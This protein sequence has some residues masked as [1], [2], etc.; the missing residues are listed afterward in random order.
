MEYMYI[1]EGA[2]WTVII[3]C[4]SYASGSNYLHG[5]SQGDLCCYFQATFTSDLRRLAWGWVRVLLD[6]PPGW[7]ASWTV[8]LDGALY[9]TI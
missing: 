4:T 1:Q 8:L 6:G 5:R 9:C 7:M 3:F 2:E